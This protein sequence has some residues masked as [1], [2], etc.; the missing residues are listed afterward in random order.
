MACFG[1]NSSSREDEGKRLLQ[2]SFPASPSKVD[3]LHHPKVKFDLPA[4]YRFFPSD[5]EM[6]LDF[7]LNKIMGY[8]LLD[9]ISLIDLYCYDP[10]LLPKSKCFLSSSLG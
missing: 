10:P 6:I 5:D 4:S 2:Q 8:E 9:I 1:S 3:M 7:F